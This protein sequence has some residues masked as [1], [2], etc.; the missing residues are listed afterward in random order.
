MKSR[1]N[2]LIF[3]C[4]DFVYWDFVTYVK[5][6][7]VIKVKDLLGF[8]GFVDLSTL[9]LHEFYRIGPCKKNEINEM[10]EEI[11]E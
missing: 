1:L 6:F 7:E 10:K 4:W 8:K 3:V 11:V 9:V 5:L 2:S